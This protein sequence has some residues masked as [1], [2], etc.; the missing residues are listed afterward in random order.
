M[1][2]VLQFAPFWV[3][4][5][6]LLICLVLG[7]LACSRASQI[8]GKQD[9]PAIVWDETFGML[10]VLLCVPA[11]PWWWAPAFAA[12]R[13]FDIM[14]PWPVRYADVYTDGG[15]AIMLDDILAAIYSVAFI[16]LIW[17]IVSAFFTG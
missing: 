15:V 12:F 16:W 3:V 8:L 5:A 14:K 4:L 13:F 2:A 10:L 9:H 1:F 11:G 6:T 7:C 17:S